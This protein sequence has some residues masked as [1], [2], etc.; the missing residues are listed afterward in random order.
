MCSWSSR[1]AVTACRGGCLRNSSA[2]PS[3]QTLRRWCLATRDAHGLYEK[4]G[5]RAVPAD[6]WMEKQGA[7]ERWQG[8]ASIQG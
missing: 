1:I 4:F 8:A 6:R 2:T 7:K 5:Y 3:L